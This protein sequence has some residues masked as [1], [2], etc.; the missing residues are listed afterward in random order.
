MAG[1]APSGLSG[2]QRQRVGVA[3]A[4]AAEPGI[5]LMDEPFG[6][7]D[8]LTRDALGT[9]VRSLHERLGL[10]TVMV[11]HDMA[12]AVLLADRIVVLRDGAVVAD[13]APEELVRTVTDA[14]VRG[15]LDAPR[16][17]AMR[18]AA[19]LGGGQ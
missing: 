13:G 6:A 19:R 5:L 12:E 1:R 3:R 10:T 8:P 17:Q 18:L 14:D 16:R 2:G 9:D 7:L 4:L 15:L 11:T